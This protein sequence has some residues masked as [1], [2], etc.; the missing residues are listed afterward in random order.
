M[1]AIGPKRTSLIAPHMSAFGGKADRVQTA[2]THFQAWRKPRNYNQNGAAL[3]RL[4]GVQRVA[5]VSFGVLSCRAI[6][7]SFIIWPVCPSRTS[8]A[9]NRLSGT[10]NFFAS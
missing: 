1:S 2:D 9:L 8:N 5:A 7:K 3:A 10:P 6:A 4:E